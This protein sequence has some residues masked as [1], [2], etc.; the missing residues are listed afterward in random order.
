MTGEGMLDRSTLMGKGVGEVAKRCRVAGVPCI[1]IGGALAEEEAL[2][3]PFTRVYGLVPCFVTKDEAYSNP[4]EAIK[5]VV[6][7]VA[8]RETWQ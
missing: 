7:S 6:A 5:R 8:E 3:P 4:T 2:V 1:G